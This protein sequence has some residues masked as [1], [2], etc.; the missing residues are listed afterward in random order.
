M[1]FACI[2]GAGGVLCKENAVDYKAN[3]SKAWKAE[4]PKNCPFPASTQE[5]ALASIFDWCVTLNNETG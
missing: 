3:F 5:E 1:I 4:Y 2:W